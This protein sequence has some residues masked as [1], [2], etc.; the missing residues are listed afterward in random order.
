[1]FH[2]SRICYHPSYYIYIYISLKRY[3]KDILYLSMYIYIYIHSL[4]VPLNFHN[5]LGKSTGFSPHPCLSLSRFPGVAN[6]ATSPGIPTP[7]S[8]IGKLDDRVVHNIHIM[9]YSCRI[10]WHFMTMTILLTVNHSDW[11]AGYCSSTIESLPSLSWKWL[12][13]KPS[14]VE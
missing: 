8:D 3:Y 2:K 6:V 14:S 5:S 11:L 12:E 10:I 7:Q 1:M 13:V 4:W 9:A